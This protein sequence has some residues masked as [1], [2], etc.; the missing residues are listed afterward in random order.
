MA[1]KKKSNNMSLAIDIEM[2]D[3]LK[4][5]AK[6]RNVP[7]SKLIR[8]IVNKHVGKEVVDGVI[9]DTVILKIPTLVKNDVE[10]LKTWLNARIETIV[11]GL[12]S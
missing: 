8:D 11:K 1:K 9:F 3:R 4:K 2:Q 6:M 10:E 7:V 12:T 5:V